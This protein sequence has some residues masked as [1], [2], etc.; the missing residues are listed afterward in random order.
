MIVLDLI[1]QFFYEFNDLGIAKRAW[2]IVLTPAFSDNNKLFDGSGYHCVTIASFGSKNFLIDCSY[3]QFFTANK[4]LLERT[5]IV[6]SFGCKPGRFMLMTDSRLHLVNNLLTRGWIEHN[7]NTLKDYMDG[8]A[9]FY[10]NGLYYEETN[11]YSYTTRYNAQDY[12]N[13]LEKKDNQLNYES[14]KTLGYQRV[15]SIKYL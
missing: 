8:F 12:M 4:N 1:N 6:N 15:P 10:R 14:I 13:F 5:G 7:D 11:D 9:I 3:S 2:P